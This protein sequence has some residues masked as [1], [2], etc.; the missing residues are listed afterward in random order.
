M[1]F[2][3]IAAFLLVSICWQNSATATTLH[4]G[5]APDITVEIPQG[6]TACDART[7]TELG[8]DAPLGQMKKL[9]DG[10]DDKGGATM[11]GT[12]DGMLALNFASLDRSKVFSSTFF[13]NTNQQQISDFGSS[14]CV[15]AFHLS[16]KTPCVFEFDKVADRRA[17]VGRIST[18]NGEFEVGRVVL[19]PDGAKN[20]VFIFFASVPSDQT[21]DGMNAIVHSI[22][23]QTK[24][25]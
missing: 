17:L 2:K 19:L 18:P 14:V 20:S 8:G 10:F 21:D 1:E 13:E 3:F 22:R 16:S 12:P 9:C 6:W 25:P 11:V 24:G 4:V 7:R 15:S 23:I 5:F